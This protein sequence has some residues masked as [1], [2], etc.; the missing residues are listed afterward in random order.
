MVVII[1][2]LGEGLKISVQSKPLLLGNC[3][4]EWPPAAPPVQ[5]SC[6]DAADSSQKASG[7]LVVP[8]TSLTGDSQR[9]VTSCLYPPQT[10]VRIQ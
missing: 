4:C 1:L 2:G 7:A 6:P 8:R 10:V 9:L 5:C 3:L